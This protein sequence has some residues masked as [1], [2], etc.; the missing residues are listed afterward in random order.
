VRETLGTFSN[1]MRSVTS[2]RAFWQ[3]KFSHWEPMP[4]N[5]MIETIM[6]IRRR[7]GMKEEIPRA[8]E[9]MDTL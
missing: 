5:L 7:K 1:E 9:F 2:G 3:T 6:E 8:E 4:K